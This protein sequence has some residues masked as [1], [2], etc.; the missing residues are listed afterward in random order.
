MDHLSDNAADAIPY[1]RLLVERDPL[2]EHSRAKLSGFLVRLGRHSEA[3][4]VIEIGKRLA[5]ELGTGKSAAA[6]EDGA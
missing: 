4:Q 5:I 6:G 2:D 1:A 3:R